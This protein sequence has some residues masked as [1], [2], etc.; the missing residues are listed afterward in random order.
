MLPDS[1]TF[2]LSRQFEIMDTNHT[3]QLEHD[4][5]MEAVA[6]AGLIHITSKDCEQMIRE[7]DMTGTKTIFYTEFIAATLNMKNILS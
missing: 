1:D 5:L 4:E 7:I 3:C 6:S 2:N